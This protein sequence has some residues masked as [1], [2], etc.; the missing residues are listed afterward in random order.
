MA[1]NKIVWNDKSAT[2]SMLS[3]IFILFGDQDWQGGVFK[4]IQND[5]FGQVKGWVMFELHKIKQVPHVV[6]CTCKEWLMLEMHKTI[7]VS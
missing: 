5:H 4:V 7:R 2:C 3:I 1:Y 6:E